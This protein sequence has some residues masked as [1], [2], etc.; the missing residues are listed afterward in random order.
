MA[1]KLDGTGGVGEGE[2]AESDLGEEA[3]VVEQLVLPEDLGDDLLG[4]P[5]SRAPRGACSVVE[6]AAGRSWPRALGMLSP[7]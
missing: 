5:G 7:M 2:A 6:G 3:V 1:S 4:L